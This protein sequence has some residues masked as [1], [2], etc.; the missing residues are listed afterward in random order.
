MLRVLLCLITCMCAGS[1]HSQQSTGEVLLGAGINFG[2]MLEAPQEGDWG[3]TFDAKYIALSKEAGFDHIRLPVR[4]ST[5]IAASAPYRIDSSFL[6]R[7]ESIVRQALQADLTVVLNVHHF[8]EIVESPDESNIAKLR[9]IWQQI[10]DRFEGVD[11]RV[12]FEILNE[13]HGALNA[14]KWNGLLVEMLA[15][16]REKHPSR[17]VI[18]GPVNWNAYDQLDSL[19]LPANDRRL[20]ATFHYYLPFD[21]THQGAWWVD[22]VRPTGLKWEASDSEI[23]EIKEHFEKVAQ[24]G[25]LHDRPLYLGEFGA[26]QAADMDSRVRWTSTVRSLAQEHK[27]GW[28]YWELASGFGI[29]NPET[30]EW[31]IP[32]MRA[33]MPRQ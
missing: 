30:Q 21:F 6:D 22:P 11:D 10:C 15:V 20:I 33:L 24:W 1:V 12:Y 23:A 29:L 2:N 27:M 16:I 3:L 17:W 31:R 14:E 28:A 18:I 13:P 4:W 7:V 26:F 8:E 9:S 5:H 19:I 25:R 32:L